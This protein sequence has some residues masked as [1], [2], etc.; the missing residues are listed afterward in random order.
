MT[1]G[2]HW[3]PSSSWKRLRFNR[4]HG[5][6]TLS[7][8]AALSGSPARSLCGSW[9]CWGTS[10]TPRIQKCIFIQEE[11]LLVGMKT[12]GCVTTRLR[13]SRTNTKAAHPPQEVQPAGHQ[14]QT[15]E[16]LTG[17]HLP[18]IS[19]N[20]NRRWAGERPDI[21]L[22]LSCSAAGSWSPLP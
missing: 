18:I 3:L 2:R 22:A 17:D 20:R 1:A 14:Q 12:D 13:V 10:P 9:A 7:P 21:L 19:P 5:I 15:Q 11:V 4:S 8:S 16:P 6:V